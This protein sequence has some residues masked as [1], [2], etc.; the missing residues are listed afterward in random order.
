MKALLV[1]N[2]FLPQVGGIQQYT[3][4]IARRLPGSTVLAAAH[5]NAV[6]SDGTQPYPVHRSRS[7]YMLPTSATRATIELTLKAEG[8]DVVMFMTSWP[9]PL[10]GPKLPVPYVVCTHGAELTIP[11]RAPGGRALIG[12]GLR[13][14]SCVFS[15]S[16]FTGGHVHR[17]AATPVRLLRTG[18]PLETFRPD[19]DGS[20][21]RRRHD[22]GES[23]VVVCVGRLVP[24]KGQDVLV[25]AWPVVRRRVPGA[26][27]L[28]VGD[29]PRRA[30]LEREA[31]EGVEFA[32]RVPWE[33]LPQYHAAANVFCS[34]VRS[35]WAGLEQEGF[36]V[37]FLD[38]QACARP[39]VA[40]RS[41]GSPESL[42]DGE[43]GLV[44][45]GASVEGVADAVA[46]LLCDPERAQR[47]G[48]AGRRF[49]ESEF[50]WDTIITG[51][52]DVLDDVVAGRPIESNL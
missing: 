20:A 30:R 18:V 15:V 49:V 31:G 33:E 43:T 16:R 10:L 48:A 14:A 9:L 38:A 28:L 51:L 35:R 4:N 8:S 45:D 37:I 41:G 2:D 24:R 42:V 29:G 25:R 5:P 19:V 17:V 40:G 11:S 27:L 21:M 22:L 12:R 26:R 13:G 32:G 47:M 3:D 1:T 34:P 44:V 6:P 46:S 50:N 7:R 52:M 39:V 36:G 23:P